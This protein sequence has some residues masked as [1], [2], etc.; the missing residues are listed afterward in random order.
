[1]D[2]P[3]PESGVR[4]SSTDPG[5]N[6]T[7]EMYHRA[8]LSQSISF[9]FQFFFLL[10]WPIRHRPAERERERGSKAV[11]YHSLCLSLPFPLSLIPCSWGRRQLNREALLFR[12]AWNSETWQW[13]RRDTARI[14]SGKPR[15]SGLLNTPEEGRMEWETDWRSLDSLNLLIKQL[16]VDIQYISLTDTSTLW[17]AW[18]EWNYTAPVSHIIQQ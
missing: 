1:M 12:R 7:G 8:C 5:L 11:S 13:R 4:T 16:K 17:W 14:L 2:T 15:G 9:L 6:L 3:Q 18:L 10:E